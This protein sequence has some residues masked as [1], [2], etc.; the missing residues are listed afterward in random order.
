MPADWSRQNR[1]GADQ[2]VLRPGTAKARPGWTTG[3]GPSQRGR[4]PV[5]IRQRVLLHRNARAHSLGCGPDSVEAGQ[6]YSPVPHGRHRS[7]VT[8]TLPMLS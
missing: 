1:L 8:M 3:P 2:M 4:L 6:W 7:A 5:P